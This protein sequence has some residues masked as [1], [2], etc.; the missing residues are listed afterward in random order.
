MP[1]AEFVF[2]V[3]F[4]S[5]CHAAPSSGV[6]VEEHRHECFGFAV[7]IDSAQKSVAM[8]E[9]VCKSTSRRSMRSVGTTGMSCNSSNAVRYLLIDDIDVCL[10]SSC[11]HLMKIESRQERPRRIDHKRPV[12]IIVPPIDLVRFFI[13]IADED[14]GYRRNTISQIPATIVSQVQNFF[15][16]LA[17][18]I[19]CPRRTFEHL[20][21]SF[22]LPSLVFSLVQAYR[23]Y[24]NAEKQLQIRC[25]CENSIP[26][27][28][29]SE[30][31]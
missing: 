27:E 16:N 13:D 24:A 15:A 11:K 22:C 3:A 25:R 10:G 4:I 5:R 12:R 23:K 30:L 18:K 26:T 2:N 31:A 14:S 19:F 20:I 7:V 17:S 21:H 9:L 6:V 28:N 8:G 1:F 29:A